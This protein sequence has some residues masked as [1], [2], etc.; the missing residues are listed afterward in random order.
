MSSIITNPDTDPH[1]YEAKPSDARAIASARYVIENGIGYDPWA[2]K[3]LDANPDSSRKVLNVGKLRRREGGR[4]PAPVVLADSV[5][6][7]VDRVTADL[8]SLDPKNVGVLPSA[9]GHVR[10]DRAGAVQ[11]V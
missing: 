3:L 4:Q 6:R 1:D 7:V 8:A 2:Q 11:R 9:E 5:Q 10:D